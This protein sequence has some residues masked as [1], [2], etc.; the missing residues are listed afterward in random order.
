VDISKVFG[1]HGE[2]L[3]V[4]VSDN[5][6]CRI[7]QGPAFDMDIVESENSIQDENIKVY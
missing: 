7:T 2:T 4:I 6:I 3:T 5:F 1:K